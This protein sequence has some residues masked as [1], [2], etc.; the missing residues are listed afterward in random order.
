[1]WTSVYGWRLG[2]WSMMHEHQEQ[3]PAPAAHEAE[4]PAAAPGGANSPHAPVQAVYVRTMGSLPGT[5]RLTAN[6]EHL[7]AH[8]V[9]V[10]S[11]QT[12][13]RRD[14]GPEASTA[15]QT[16]YTGMVASSVVDTTPRPLG[17][18][19][20]SSGSFSPSPATSVAADPAEDGGGLGDVFDADSA[21]DSPAPE[22]APEA[23]RPRRK[24]PL[25][26]CA[27]VLCVCCVCG[28]TSMS[29]LLLV[30]HARSVQVD[31]WSYREGLHGGPGVVGPIPGGYV[32]SAAHIDSPPTP[33]PFSPPTPPSPP[34]PW[35]PPPPSP[36]PPRP[37]PPPPPSPAPPPPHPSRPPPHPPPQPSPPPTPIPPSSPPHVGSGRHRR[38][39]RRRE[40][41][42]PELCHGFGCRADIY[43]AGYEHKSADFRLEVF[44]TSDPGA[45]AAVVD[46]TL[47]VN[48]SQQLPQSASLVRFGGQTLST[49]PTLFAH[50]PDF[51]P[52]DMLPSYGTLSLW[53]VGQKLVLSQ[54]AAV[55]FTPR[56]CVEGQ[57]LDEV[58]FASFGGRWGV[59]YGP[60]N[61][62]HGH[63]ASLRTGPWTCHRGIGKCHE[64]CYA[65]EHLGHCT[66][67]CF[68]SMQVD[69]AAYT[70]THL[71]AS[72]S[73]GA[74]DDASGS[75]QPSGRRR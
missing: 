44:S 64:P 65:N 53:S 59:R 26:L 41:G 47:Y 19:L 17:G 72:S 30:L 4:P 50:C 2:C 23:T 49:R 73:A 25:G 75:A 15:G 38:H 1:M 3:A 56:H 5:S 51:G 40:R 29:I 68:E 27:L 57:H 39:R 46:F 7:T 9:P 10:Y 13:R 22:A 43:Q 45:V 28:G 16:P 32:A 69:D 6:A 35:L 21:A 12:P 20:A 54:D 48:L 14:T 74:D 33:P 31:T 66:E 36:S 55:R 61:T 52:Y 63:A 18:S 8:F 34:V 67:A 24:R 71:D 42:P 11:D 62:S 37:R 58:E 60:A 70:L